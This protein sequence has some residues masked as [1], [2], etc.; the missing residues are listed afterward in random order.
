MKPRVGF[1]LL[2]QTGLTY[3]LQQVRRDLFKKYGSAGKKKMGVRITL[4]KSLVVCVPCGEGCECV[5]C[6]LIPPAELGTVIELLKI[7]MV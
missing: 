7:E 1:N 2:F 3:H 5:L 4:K 6:G